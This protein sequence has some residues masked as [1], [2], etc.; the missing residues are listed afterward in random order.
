MLDHDIIIHYIKINNLNDQLLISLNIPRIHELEIANYKNKNKELMGYAVYTKL[1]NKENLIKANNLHQILKQK[2]MYTNLNNITI[3]IEDRLKQIKEVKEFNVAYIEDK[4]LL[5][6]NTRIL[7]EKES[8]EAYKNRITKTLNIFNSIAK[9][10]PIILCLQE[11]YP[12]KLFSEVLKNMPN[13]TIIDKKVSHIKSNSLVLC[14]KILSLDIKEDTEKDPI[15][16]LLQEKGTAKSFSKIK[17]YIINS[18]KKTIEL[19]NI[20]LLY[21]EKKQ[22]DIMLGLLNSINSDKDTI[23]IGD[24]NFKLNDD[25]IKKYTTVFATKGFKIMFKITPEEQY[26]IPNKNPT[27]DISIISKSLI[28]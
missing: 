7:I 2:N 22:N 28:Q 13:L 6:N 15:L 16:S 26:N 27:Y 10:Q 18:N 25:E 11:I 23:I 12:Y 1:R 20:H 19:Y 4:K 5:Y 24:F 3:S 14:S 21:N 17:K 8:E 9:N